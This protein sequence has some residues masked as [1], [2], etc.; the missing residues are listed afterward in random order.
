[1]FRGHRVK[2][3]VA[4]PIIEEGERVFA[5]LVDQRI[6]HAFIKPVEG[7][8]PSDE[9]LF[10]LFVVF[11]ARKIDRKSRQLRGYFVIAKKSDDFLAD[12]SLTDHIDAV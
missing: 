8:I 10:L 1:M 7:K 9:L 2:K 5:L 3:F 12:V 6:A 11:S 4:F